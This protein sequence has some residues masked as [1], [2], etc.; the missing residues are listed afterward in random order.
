MAE[1]R[2]ETEI[3][4]LSAEREKTGVFIGSHAINPMTSGA[5]PDL[6][7]GLRAARLRHRRDHGRARPRRARRRLRAVLAADPVRGA[8]RSGELPDDEAFVA[9]TA[10]EVLVD[11]G[12]FS[13]MPASEAIGAITQQLADLG[14]GGPAG[15][16]RSATGWSAASAT[17]APDPDRVL[18]EHGAQPVPEDQLPVLLPRTSTSRPPGEPAAVARRVP[19]GQL[20]GVRRRSAPRDRH[21]G[22]L[23]RL[24]L[25]FPALLLAER[26]RA[27]LGPAGRGHW[28]PVDL[29]TGGAEH[30]V[31]HLMYS[32]FFVKALRDMG[33]LSFDE[34]FVALRNQG[35]ILGADHHRMSKSRGNVVN[36]DDLTGRY[37]RTRFG[38][39]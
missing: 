32:R 8:A 37:G 21:H 15:A 10:D 39:S 12:E 36:P 30:A 35:Q 2:R 13:G 34:P 6:G 5:H 24:G 19:E 31:L 38:C 14:I 20:P 16:T 3:E 23:R 11:S 26:R 22:H 29:Y 33:H 4:R 28:M 7:G 27:G 1:A 9:H 25:V 18:P 17:G